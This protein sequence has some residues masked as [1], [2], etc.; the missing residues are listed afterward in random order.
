MTRSIQFIPTRLFFGRLETSSGLLWILTVAEIKSARSNVTTL[1]DHHCTEVWGAESAG[2]YACRGA[3]HGAG[4]C[5]AVQGGAG[6]CREVQGRCREVQGGAGR[7]RGL[8]HGKH[9]IRCRE[10]QGVQ[11][12]LR[13]QVFDVCQTTACRDSHALPIAGSGGRTWLPTCWTDL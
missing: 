5:R 9:N 7:C 10:V 3:G 6:R 1:H 2:Y 8:H 13:F 11:A 4:R 12:H